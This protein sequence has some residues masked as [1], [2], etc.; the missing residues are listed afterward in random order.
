[1]QSPAAILNLENGT[2]YILQGFPAVSVPKSRP[3][4]A[5][6]GVG[7]CLTRR[8]ASSRIACALQGRTLRHHRPSP[9]RKRPTTALPLTANHRNSEAYSFISTADPSS[10][11][12]MVVSGEHRPTCCIIGIRTPSIPTQTA[13]STLSLF[14]L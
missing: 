2:G 4:L 1:M 12:K 8:F 3:T 13:V 6:Y 5:V 7:Q 10:G 11:I 9:R 14:T